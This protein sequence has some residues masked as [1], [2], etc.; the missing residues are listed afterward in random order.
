VLFF[1]MSTSFQTASLSAEGVGKDVD[2]LMGNGYVE[3][4]VEDTFR[5]VRKSPDLR[6]VLDDK[7]NKPIGLPNSLDQSH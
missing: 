2:L 6:H 1:G 4:C 7:L 3:N 5:L